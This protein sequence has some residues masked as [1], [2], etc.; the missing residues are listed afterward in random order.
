[1]KRPASPGFTLIELCLALGLIGVLGSVVIVR[2][3]GWTPRQELRAAARGL[4]TALRTARERA[5]FEER[6]L[7]LRIDPEGGAWAIVDPEPREAGLPEL[8]LG[9][10]RLRPGLRFGRI[11]LGKQEWKGR[12]DLALLPNGI[13][14]EVD[15]VI[16]QEGED[17]T[18]VHVLLGSLSNDVSYREEGPR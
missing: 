13:L 10:G 6:S 7:L 3:E 1:M 9:I 4:G 5:Q 15:L 16:E 2:V 8:K 17:R 18:V 14:P 11:L 12:L